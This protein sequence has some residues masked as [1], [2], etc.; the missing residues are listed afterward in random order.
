MYCSIDF[1]AENLTLSPVLPVTNY[2]SP[3]LR[4][5]NDMLKFRGK[6]SIRKDAFVFAFY[7]FKGRQRLEVVEALVRFQNTAYAAMQFR[8]FH[9]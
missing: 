9:V 4:I 2:V 5:E 6:Y 3:F 8:C 7:L 1:P